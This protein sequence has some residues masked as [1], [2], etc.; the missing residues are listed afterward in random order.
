MAAAGVTKISCRAARAGAVVSTHHRNTPMN[1]C[2]ILEKAEGW[3]E[4]VRT[5]QRNWMAVAKATLVDFKLDYSSRN[6]GSARPAPP[7]ASYNARRYN[8]RRHLRSNSRLSIPSVA[9]LAASNTISRARDQLIGEQRKRPKKAGDI[10]DNWEK[11]GSPFRQL[12]INSLQQGKSSVWVAKLQ[13]P[14]WIY[15][16]RAS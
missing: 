1:C 4:K 10:G 2:A 13:N 15:G 6:R 8:L 3:P 7:S 11:H 14:S 9:D 16:H 5:M 12:L